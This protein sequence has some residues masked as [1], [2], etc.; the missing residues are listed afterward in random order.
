M[1]LPTNGRVIIDTTVGEIDIELWSKETPKTCRNFLALAMEGYYDGVIFHRVV[2]G[3][4]V[5]TGDKTGTGMGGESFYGEPFE[6]EI[7]PR[8]RFAHRGLVAMANNGQKNSNDSQFIITLD[9]ADE[10]HG[11]HTLFGRCIG[12]TLYNVMKIGE[13][14]LDANERP[15]YPPKIKGIRIIDNPF[16]D[17]IP[18]ITAAE[19]RAQQR[20]REEALKE[21]EEYERRKNA[22]K[23]V[24][25]LSFGV[26]EGDEEETIV[27]KKK[28]IVRPDL[29]DQPV[30]PTVS[31]VLPDFVTQGSRTTS[32]NPEK[33]KDQEKEKG[34]ADRE[35]KSK[36]RK[37][38]DLSKIREAHAAEK[39]NSTTARQTEIS[40]MEAEIR[41]LTKR[42]DGGDDDSDDERKKKKPKTSYLEAE[43]G[44]YAS[45]RGIKTKGS[46]GK[47]R[48][49][50]ERDVL[51]VLNAFRGKLQM[52]LPA[53]PEDDSEGK[54]GADGTENNLLKHEEAKETQ[55]P[56]ANFPVGEDPG[57]E[58]DN[59]RGFLG[60]SLHFPKDDG[61]ESRKAERDYEVIDP[62][63]RGAR[64]KE[65]EKARKAKAKYRDGGRGS[66]GRGSSGGGY[67][68]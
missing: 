52:A 37:D 26:D 53:A 55:P 23:D 28:P 19:R 59:D 66:R 15:V 3:F 12:D 35:K 9:R 51:N 32:N 36:E 68:R 17:I 5:Q 42:R 8:L 44:K 4:L 18:R 1:A 58:I 13:L 7:H 24:K 11:K 34:D 63:Q 16:P 47:G 48:A 61:E 2:P 67:Q 30:A 57:I 64:A 6:D 39:A 25:L 62:R 10:L 22:K 56:P 65:E 43:L 38:I 46:K 45:S 54:I 40:R 31:G 27:F 60:H 41:K 21:R 20:A 50:D 29:I 49:K 33:K 14:E